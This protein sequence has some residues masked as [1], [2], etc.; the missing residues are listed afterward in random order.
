MGV[1]MR[2][3]DP[4]SLE[5]VRRHDQDLELLAGAHN[6]LG[7]LIEVTWHRKDGSAMRL[8]THATDE[9]RAYLAGRRA[10]AEKPR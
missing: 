6:E 9:A 3:L 10:K 1:E 5:V 2:P 4:V 8:L 7:E